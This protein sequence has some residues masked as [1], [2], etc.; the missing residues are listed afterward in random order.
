M[1]NNILEHLA[2]NADYYKQFHAGD[3]LGNADGYFKFGNYCDSIIDI[4]F[5]VTTKALNMNLSFYQKR[6]DG[7]I[8]A[9]E[10]T[11]D[12]RVREVYLTCM[13]D[14]ENTTY[15]HCDASLLF[16]KPSQLLEIDRSIPTRQQIM[17]QQ[18]DFEVID[19]TV[20]FDTNPMQQHV[21]FPYSK[22]D[23]QFPTHLFINKAPEWVDHLP[24]DINSMKI[25][26]IKCW[27]RECFERT[28][29]L[30]YIK[31]HSSRR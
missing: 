3:L 21:Y 30:R 19:L 18:Q 26:K 12:V 4:I 11:T 15:N 14:P 6:P 1:V 25:F 16:D 31:M 2:A 28:H 20:D 29:N 9:I 17:M 27:P 5:I 13:Q 8:Q 10:Q 23:T 24:G 7:N 22:N